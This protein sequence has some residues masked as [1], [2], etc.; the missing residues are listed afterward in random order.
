[1]TSLHRFILAVIIHWMLR[2]IEV[3]GHCYVS[4]WQSFSL[5]KLFELLWIFI[6]IFLSL[7]SDRRQG[8]ELCFI[9]PWRFSDIIDSPALIQFLLLKIFSTFRINKPDFEILTAG[10]HP[11]KIFIVSQHDVSIFF[12]WRHTFLKWIIFLQ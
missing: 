11:L 6:S 4:N 8:T 5:V 3:H 9:T 10:F 7:L 1:M 12:A 2:S